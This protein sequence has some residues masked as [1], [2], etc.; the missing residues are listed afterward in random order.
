MKAPKSP[1]VQSPISWGSHFPHTEANSPHG[2]NVEMKE[3]NPM[4][5]PTALK[6]RSMEEV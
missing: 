6:R 5:S 4:T 3:R 2:I 1:E